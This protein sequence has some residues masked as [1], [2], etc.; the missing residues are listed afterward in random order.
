MKNLLYLIGL[1]A[2]AAVAISVMNDEEVSMPPS[3]TVVEEVQ[4][5]ETMEEDMVADDTE[6]ME[7]DMVADDTET[8]EEEIVADDTETM[9][10][11]LEMGMDADVEN[12]EE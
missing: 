4:N 7:E 12:S 10:A 5:T 6:T 8:M 2:I 1:V 3:N 9:E 11:D